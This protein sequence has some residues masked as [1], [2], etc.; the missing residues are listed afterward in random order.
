MNNTRIN[1]PIITPTLGATALGGLLA[2][3]VTGATVAAAA[4]A[5][6]LKKGTITKEEAAANVVREAG[7]M[8]LATTLGVTATA[9]TGTTGILSVAGVAL[10]TAGSKYAIDSLLEAGSK[11][12]KEAE[13]A[14]EEQELEVTNS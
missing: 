6:K 14:T 7:S 10:F 12:N 13:E 1:N 9:L 4:N 11:K 2:G 3:V 8:G 5:R